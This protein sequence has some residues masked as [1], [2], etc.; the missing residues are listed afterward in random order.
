MSRSA[1]LCLRDAKHS[2]QTADTFRAAATFFDLL[3]IWGPL[4]QD[5]LSKSKYAKHH[6]LRIQKA[7]RAGED[8]NTYNLPQSL[9]Q[10]QQSNGLSD[11]K[12][13]K[14][15]TVS[16]Q[17]DTTRATAAL[18]HGSDE[19][20]REA[21][22]I[23][24]PNTQIGFQNITESSEAATEFNQ[25]S[26]SNSNYSKPTV[27]EEHSQLLTYTP[28]PVRYNM[29]GSSPEQAVPRSGRAMSSGNVAE[30]PTVQSSYQVP[31]SN[32]ER[33][34]DTSQ[35]ASEA[36]PHKSHYRTD[37]NAIS[38]AQKHAKWAVSALNF[39]DVDTAV[40]ELK[41]ALDA[42]GAT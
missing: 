26:L 29:S 25:G 22:S 12:D 42:L 6:A 9:E 10:T 35:A 15:V 27:E 16:P 33:R 18:Q 14:E 3:G 39:E 8:P 32:T 19:E 28:E 5:V 4:S 40:E 21:S 37:D 38:D 7:I 23:I 2:R 1:E 11:A 41:I 20:N 34:D 13:E 17:T 36:P 31:S 30:M 24:P